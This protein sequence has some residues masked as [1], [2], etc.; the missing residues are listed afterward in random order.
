VWKLYQFEDFRFDGKTLE[1]TRDG[2]EVALSPKSAVLLAE[3]LASAGELLTKEVLLERVWRDAVVGED[4]LKVR[5]NELRK[6]LGDK[7]ADSRFIAT[8]V[9]RG[10]RFVAKV[11]NVSPEAPEPW[12]RPSV[13]VLPFA[14]D[15]DDDRSSA[16]AIGLSTAIVGNLVRWGELPAVAPPL[17]ERQKVERDPRRMGD[18]LDAAFIVECRVERASERYRVSY[19]FTSTQSGARLGAGH[20]DS[21]G[22]D[23]LA[24]RDLAAARIVKAFRTSFHR[25]APRPESTPESRSQQAWDYV[26]RGASFFQ[27]K[28]AESNKKA[29]ECFLDALELDPDSATCQTDLAGTH[30]EDLLFGWFD[31]FEGS[32]D[33]A[34][35]HAERAIENDPNLATA[36]HVTCGAWIFRGDGQRP[37]M[38]IDRAL[39]LD[40]SNAFFLEGRAAAYLKEGRLKEAGS[41]IRTCL[42]AL[43]SATTDDVS[44]KTQALVAMA[45]GDS[46]LAL[47]SAER[48]VT[49]APSWPLHG[50]VATIHAHCGRI[51]EA[52]GAIERARRFRSKLSLSDALV[53]FRVAEPGAI[54]R[55]RPDLERLGLRD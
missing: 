39:E 23:L 20:L 32:T 8:V 54:E 3:L 55:Y 27:Q 22:E 33:A 45:R 44:L 14:Y 47:R 16:L 28:T 51:D 7:P 52:E 24:F 53:C 13:A 31:S 6:A 15:E 36:H 38:H 49:T 26:L 11:K 10:Y 4:S 5:I 19:E 2:N 43:G 12:F 25:A 1:L 41:T 40:P 46:D 17:S 50:L 34:M 48:A 37:G 42:D 29:R 30:L 18:S 9:R 35:Y 21:E